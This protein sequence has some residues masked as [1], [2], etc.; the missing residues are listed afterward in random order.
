MI[1]ILKS[2]VKAMVDYEVELQA[3]V[4]AKAK[5]ELKN[6]KRITQSYHWS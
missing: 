2:L 3:E 6:K 4:E 5:V 1:M